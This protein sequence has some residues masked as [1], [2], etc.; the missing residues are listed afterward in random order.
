MN[1]IFVNK[2]PVKIAFLIN[3]DQSNWEEWIDAIWKHCQEKWGGRYNPIIPTD[4]KSIDEN[5][6]YFLQ[7]FDPDYLISVCPLE[8]KLIE[9]IKERISPI[10]IEQPRNVNDSTLKPVI[11]TSNE[12]IPIL[13][14]KSNLSKFSRIISNNVLASIRGSDWKIDKNVFQFLLRNFGIYDDIYYLDKTLEKLTNIETFRAHDKDELV[15]LVNDLYQPTKDFV[16]PIQYSMLGKPN[17]WLE[18]DLKHSDNTFGIIIGDTINEQIFLRNKVFYERDC[19]HK[20][21]N[22][23]WLPTVLAND[24]DVISALGKWLGRETECIHLFSFSLS[25]SEIS[26]IGEQLI[27]SEKQIKPLYIDGITTE[28]HFPSYSE[29][30]TFTTRISPSKEADFYRIYNEKERFDIKSPSQTD[31]LPKHGNWIG[32]IFIELNKSKFLSYEWNH[33]PFWWRIPRKNY[34]VPYIISTNSA[35]GTRAKVSS[36]GIPCVQFSA[37]NPQLSIKLQSDFE[38]LRLA[39]VRPHWY[40]TKDIIKVTDLYTQPSNIGKYLN[41][42]INVYGSLDNAY[43]ALSSRY[44]RR[45]FDILSKRDLTKDQNVFES[46]KSKLSKR[47]KAF[48]SQTQILQQIGDLAKDV[49]TLARETAF[50]SK[51]IKFAELAEQCEKEYADFNETENETW[52]FDKDALRKEV[53]EFL[54]LGVFLTGISQSCPR[55]GSV[56]WYEVEKMSQFLVCEGCKYKFSLKA[57]PIWSYRLNSLVHQGI[58][59]HGLVPV[60]LVLGQLLRNSRSSFFYSPSLNLFRIIDSNTSESKL[61]GDLDIVCISDSKLIIGE[62]K[63]SQ[64]LFEKNQMLK[65]AD[66]AVEV[67]ADVLL[68]SSLDSKPNSKTLGFIEEVKEKIKDKNIHVEWYQLEEHIFDPEPVR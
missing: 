46:I 20:G 44:W 8:D 62:I 49:L 16:Y 30:N 67:S 34:L 26:V 39:L 19:D 13:P 53:S 37:E 51:I 21:I 58:S 6:L 52:K 42:F 7:R 64:S 17:W 1:S 65:L 5:W 48:G 31:D 36:S 12:G 2:R 63:Q 43:Q 50:E 10:A 9:I 47:I 22:Y 66:I 38:F 35:I 55:C 45:I 41:G 29:H 11:H 61:L 27:N 14:T 4:G 24:P 57:E 59:M 28:L 60:V 32:E 25:E 40:E 18:F 54:N 15:K 33:E 23:I 68:F 56:N 3:P